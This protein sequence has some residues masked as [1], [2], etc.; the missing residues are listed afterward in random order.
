MNGTKS[1]NKEWNRLSEQYTGSAYLSI[2]QAALNSYFC[3]SIEDQDIAGF[4]NNGNDMSELP[5]CKGRDTSE[6][7]I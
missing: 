7:G 2:N 4:H 6:K 1:N 3:V 5:W